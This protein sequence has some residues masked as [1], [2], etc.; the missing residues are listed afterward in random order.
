MRSE[1][2]HMRVG[3]PFIRGAPNPHI[4]DTFWTK[5][6]NVQFAYDYV[7]ALWRVQ[8]KL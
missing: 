7:K 3:V 8:L 4:R 2:P 5:M 1:I 6:S